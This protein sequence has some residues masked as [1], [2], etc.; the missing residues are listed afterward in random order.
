MANGIDNTQ[1][2]FSNVSYYCKPHVVWLHGTD[3][4]P[5]QLDVSEV[6]DH[7]QDQHKACLMLVLT[8]LL[9]AGLNYS[10]SDCQ[11]LYGFKS[12]VYMPMLE[13]T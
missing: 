5:E 11:S 7:L 13:H 9:V 3:F 6:Q 4:V 10:V 2:T 12:M 1:N 8:F